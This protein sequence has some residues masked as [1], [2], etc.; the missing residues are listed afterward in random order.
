MKHTTGGSRGGGQSGHG[1]PMTVLG[2]L[3]RLARPESV[4][5]N[6]K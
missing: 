4:K 6:G 1:P 2:G 3:A 5:V